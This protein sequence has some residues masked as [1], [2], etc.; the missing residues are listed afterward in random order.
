MSV[1]VRDDVLCPD[2][3]YKIMECAFEVHTILGPGFTE[4]I[5]EEAMAYEFEL[6]AIPFE[7]QKIT[8]VFYKGRRL[9][10]YRLDLLVD[11]KIILKL[12]AVSE[13]N[14]IF[15]QKTFSYLTS[16]NLRLGIPINFGSKRVGSHR[17][18]N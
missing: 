5:Y 12:K 11:G 1:K 17:I 4:D 14:D 2:L 13:L 16:T 18:V 6:H 9:G 8:D 3:S 15:K 7:R 10:K